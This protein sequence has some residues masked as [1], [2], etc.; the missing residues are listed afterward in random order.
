MSED[1][2]RINRK[3]EFEDDAPLEYR[4]TSAEESLDA[5]FKS[6]TEKIPVERK[7]ST[8]LKLLKKPKTLHS[9]KNKDYI[10]LRCAICQMDFQT[11]RKDE[12]GNFEP[13]AL[14][15]HVILKGVIAEK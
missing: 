1:E 15:Q 14:C 4:E 11:A 10:I 13:V 3:I 7:V 8:P 9:F 5:A 2:A 6:V 12:Q